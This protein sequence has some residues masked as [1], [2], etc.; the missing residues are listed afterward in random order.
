[1]K[2]TLL[3]PLLFALSMNAFS[4]VNTFAINQT[5]IGPG[6]LSFDLNNDGDD[7]FSFDIV[8]LSPDV[9][10][11]R[12]L[13]IGSST[14]LD[15]STFGYPD[16]LN[17]GDAVSGNFESGNGV[18]GTISNAG[19]F[20]G[21]GDKYLGIKIAASGNEHLGW[22]KVN[23]SINRDTL[24][25]ISCGYNTSASAHIK[26]GQTTI[27]S[28]DDPE[29]ELA[30]L[31]SIYPVPFSTQAV[32]KAENPFHDAIL[33]VVNTSGKTVKQMEHINGQSIVLSRDNLAGGVY[34]VHLI[35]DRQPIATRKI[36]I[37][38]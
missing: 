6:T 36:I 33:R 38:D 30:S 2:S 5:I 31:I 13:T 25:I 20:K 11:A 17:A 16:T 8:T 35:Q 28:I 21:A 18:L 23:C 24:N 4:Q 22:I 7:D 29:S 37:V 3:L 27:T 10:A 1:M 32:L 15:N 34:F 19:Q 26:A 12:V 9:F 14:I